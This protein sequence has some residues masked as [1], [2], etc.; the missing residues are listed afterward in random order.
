MIS[1]EKYF[2]HFIFTILEIH[3]QIFFLHL[4]FSQPDLEQ[5]MRA[6]LIFHIVIKIE[7]EV[8]TSLIISNRRNT[9]TFKN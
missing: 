9:L 2:S 3:L 8:R 7:P 1:L 4:I 6:E 5:L